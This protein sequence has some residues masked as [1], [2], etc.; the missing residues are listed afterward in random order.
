MQRNC[1]GVGSSKPDRQNRRKKEYFFGSFSN[2]SG[3][4]IFIISWSFSSKKRNR[5]INQFLFE[6]GT[7]ED[8]LVLAGPRDT[9]NKYEKFLCSLIPE[10]E[11]RIIWTGMLKG[12]QW[13]A[14]HSAN[15][16]IL[17]SHQEN[18][19]MVVAESLRWNPCFYYNKV[20][21]WR[22]IEE[23]GAGFVSEDNQ[24]G[25]NNLLSSWNKNEHSSMKEN[26]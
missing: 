14:L 11:K 16:L 20:N 19:G 6:N 26:A 8:K 18:Y 23:F 3:H 17:P 15:A 25:I 13:G 1:N 4:K 5:F 24:Q 7:K 21:L 10:N 9:S 12:D 2:S 22:E